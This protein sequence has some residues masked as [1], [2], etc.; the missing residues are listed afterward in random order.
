MLMQT[1]PYKLF[2]TRF[3]D[4]TEIQKSAIGVIEGGENCIISAPTGSGKTEAALLPVL[5]RLQNEQGKGIFA[6]Y[7]TPLRAL[8]RDLIK[9]LEWFGSELG[10]DIA[11]RHGDTTQTERRAQSL[12]PPQILITTP[13]SIQNL[14]LSPRLRS[15][16]SNLRVVIVDE[17]HELYYN[18][19]GA[20][21]SIALE[22]VEVISGSFQRIGISATIG[23][24]EDAS[25][26]LFGTRNHRTVE[27]KMKKA[28]EF[29]VELPIKPEK[30]NKEFRTTF[31][32]DPQA[33]A[34]IVRV[35]ELVRDSNATLV[36]SNTRQAVESLG[37]KLI[38]LN[39][40]EKF[41]D[42]GIHHS[43]IDK[44]ERIKVENDFKDGRLKALIAT[45]SLELGID[46][47]QIDLVV[48][49]GSPRQSIRLVQRVG[50]GGHREAE[51]SRGDIIVHNALDGIEALAIVEAAVGGKLE[52]QTIEYCALDVLANQ[53]SAIALEYGRIEKKMILDI[54]RKAYPYKELRE[55]DFERVL[56]L[57]SDLR[58]VAVENNAIVKRGKGRDYFIKAISVIPDSSRF[59][60]KDAAENKIIS[61]LDEEFVYNYVDDGAIFITKGLPWKVVS[62]EEDIVY[63]EQS[64][65]LNAAVPDWDGEDI[66]VSRNIALSVIEKFGS[67]VEGSPYLDL[68]ARKNLSDFISAQKEFFVPS[69][70]SV[71]IEEM[72]NCAVAYIPLGKL[73]NEYIAKL[74][75]MMASSMAG[76]RIGVKATPY[77]LI[78]DY[79]FVMKRPD[80]AKI[81]EALKNVDLGGMKFISS[82]E[83]FRYKFV[84]IAKL[85]GVVEKDAKITR[86]MANKIIS[87]YENSPIF[88]ETVRDLEKNYFDMPTAKKFIEGLRD[89]SL[90]VH[91]SRRSGS[92]LSKEILQSVYKYGELLSSIERTSVI[93]KLMEKYDGRSIKILCTYCGHVFNE[94][95]SI[96]KDRKMFCSSCKSPLLVTYSDEYDKIVAKR[97][98]GRR[99][100]VQDNETYKEMM[101]EA[102]LVDAYGDRALVAL[103]TYGIGVETAARVL[104]YIRS[105]YKMFFVDVIDAQKNFIKNRKFWK[106]D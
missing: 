60:V 34:R 85:F 20:Q 11:V 89:G 78:F 96:S 52:R 71:Y 40:Q 25:K 28:F 12:K 5:K 98:G 2:L 4:F 50:R 17:L 72:D 7:I 16:L 30:D 38:Q 101:K 68:N 76:S 80:T 55:S 26:F 67:G 8:N 102:S 13:E 45:S 95:I 88:D 97:I 36:F 91:T 75:S 63:V 49:Y 92:P 90:K 69:S 106:I 1:D 48:Q 27:S 62:I 37:S 58:L 9:R 66:P 32:L 99:F 23:N 104:K 3:A 6:I 93:E 74:M 35:G 51:K 42:V 79:S 54:V 18:K 41:G 103:S 19:R 22:R 43:S 94:K 70:D 61:T 65:D 81:F 39:K 47:G 44:N 87:F 46:V 33:Y 64:N 73:A 83:L 59:V 29:S 31:G 77:V 10:V 15:S 57:V 100:T 53:I 24:I 14:L 21:L 56:S 86:G 84:Q 105:D 82:S